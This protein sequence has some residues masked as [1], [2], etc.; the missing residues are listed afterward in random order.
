MQ[1]KSAQLEKVRKA[2]EPVF[3]ESLLIGSGSGTNRKPNDGLSLSNP[4][5][6]GPNIVIAD[7]RG[8]V[9]ISQRKDGVF[10][11]QDFVQILVYHRF[12]ETKIPDHTQLGEKVIKT[13]ERLAEDDEIFFN[14]LTR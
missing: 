6:E 2:L 12:N 14:T 11:V 8:L 5:F 10:E 4:Y 1:L 7:E 3:Q 13:M 9:V